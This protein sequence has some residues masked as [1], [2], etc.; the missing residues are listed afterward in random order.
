MRRF[1]HDPSDPSSLSVDYV[2]AVHTSRDGYVWVATYGGGLNGLDPDALD[3]GFTRYTEQNSDLPSNTIAGLLEDDTGT[4]WISTY[5]GLV[6]FDPEREVF[7]THGPD[8][9]VQSTEFNLTAYH[10]GPDGELFFGGVN[11]LNA[12]YPEDVEVNTRPPAVA[13]TE[14]VVRTQSSTGDSTLNPHAGVAI[15][16]R[17]DQ[18]DLA[19]GYVGLHYAAP[20]RN[21]YAYQLEGYDTEW[22]QVGTR[23]QVT[24]TNLNPGDYVFRVKA[25]NRDGIW[26]EDQSL[27]AFTIR[28][29]WWA[30]WGAYGSYALLLMLG[31]LAAARFQRRRLLQRER[32][33]RAE[34]DNAR[35]T[36]E[37]EEARQLQV[38][39]LPKATPAL[40]HAW[41]AARMQTATEVGGDYYDFR[42]AEGGALLFAIGDATGH[43]ARA[44]TMVAVTKTLFNSLSDEQDEGEDEGLARFLQRATGLLRRLGMRRLYMAL[45]LGRLKGGR[46]ELAGAGMPPALVYRA[47]SETVEEVPLKGMPLGGPAGFPYRQ[48][49]IELA[50]GDV[51]VLMSDGFP[52]AF[53]AERR[54]LGYERAAAVLRASA[55]ASPEEIIACYEETARR[56][57]G[58]HPL[59]DDMTFVVLKM[60]AP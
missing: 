29:P 5:G 53:D 12:F 4:L 18:N 6:Q 39:M 10:K 19:L 49:S 16:L 36:R 14:A 30:T 56:W 31:V 8:R 47:R 13:L 48:R 57:T 45:A 34:E 20:Q 15:R 7:R 42:H 11:G 43:G 44:G 55:S 59:S 51:V 28:P 32:A 38:S 17:H 21:A 60:R 1:R 9:G 33:R 24:Y 37:L 41:I 40:P 54:M 27:L 46:L 22:Q 3:E 35:K 50:P 23:R 2:V 58:E 52:E 25:A 26:S